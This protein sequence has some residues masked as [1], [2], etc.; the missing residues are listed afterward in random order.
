MK[1]YGYLFSTFILIFITISGCSQQ[2]GR[3][4]SPRL[5]TATLL[6]SLTPSPTLTGI[7]PS[8]ET[9]LAP[10][11]PEITL[12]PTFTETPQTISG[13]QQDCLQIETTMPPGFLSKGAIILSDEDANGNP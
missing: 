3:L 8:P 5:E 7:S 4:A 13:Y 6:A 9:P 12:E 2:P 11:L 1:K 10:T